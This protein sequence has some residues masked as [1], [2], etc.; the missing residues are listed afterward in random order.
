MTKSKTFED[1]GTFNVVLTVTDA[2][3]NVSQDS[4]TVKAKEQGVRAKLEAGPLTGSIPLKVTFDASGS[5]YPAGEIISYEWDFG[6]GS[7][8]QLRN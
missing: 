2:D 3:G 6:D 7:N 8:K 5:T 1:T 4:L